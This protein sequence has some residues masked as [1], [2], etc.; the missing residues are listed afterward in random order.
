MWTMS[1]SQSLFF[2]TLLGRVQ[3]RDSDLSFFPKEVVSTSVKPLIDFLNACK[4]IKIPEAKFQ[5]TE[6]SFGDF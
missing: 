3:F 5:L 1:T 2:S 4:K 6:T